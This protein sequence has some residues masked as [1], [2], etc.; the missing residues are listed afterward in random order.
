MDHRGGMQQRL[1]P[2]AT[3]DT[4][5]EQCS[6]LLVPCSPHA[7][8]FRAFCTDCSTFELPVW[9]GRGERI[10]Q[11]LCQNG[12]N[13]ARFVRGGINAYA[14]EGDPSVPTYLESDGDCTT[15]HEH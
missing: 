4:L 14:E 7:P 12:F 3:S 11:Y 2:T 1:N 15:C 5:K 9:K 10:M 13:S 6:L 8:C